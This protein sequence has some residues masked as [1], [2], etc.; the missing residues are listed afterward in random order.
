MLIQNFPA[1][2]PILNKKTLSNTAFKANSDIKD[3][4]ESSSDAKMRRYEEA[5]TNI[6]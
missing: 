2:S 1:L 3:T 4:F 6:T 5:K